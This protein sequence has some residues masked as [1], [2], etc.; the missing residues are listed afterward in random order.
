MPD[1]RTMSGMSMPSPDL[2]DGTVSVRVVRNEISNN[3]SGVTV[4]L[5]G[6]GAPRSMKTGA[7]GRA[8]FSGLPPGSTVRAVATVDGQRLESQPIE[9]PATG[10]VRT[11]LA[12]M[13]AAGAP[14]A[15]G[16]AAG[17]PAAA[18]AAPSGP[19][20]SDASVLS[21]GGNSR[22]ATEFNDDILQVFLLLEIVN[23]SSSPVSPATALVFDLPT[24]AEGTTVLDG[25]T[26]QANAKG[27]RVTVAGPF[28][29]GST[30]LQIAYRIDTFGKTLTLEQRLPLPLDAVTIAVQRLGEMKVS[31]PQVERTMENPVDRAVFV[32][33]T[34]PRLQA[35]KPLTITLSGLPHHSRMPV[36]GALGLVV[37]IVAGA[38]WLGFAPGHADAIASRRSE[39]AEQ[40]EQGLASLAALEQQHRAGTVDESRYQARRAA[41]VAQLERVYG[42]LDADGGTLGGQDIAS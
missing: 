8:V 29:P 11:I 33:G 36:Y 37:L 12:L 40:R 1:L 31:S 26:P 41:V 20:S 38:A 6:A 23:R 22:V 5:E 42:E 28:A 21:L 27:P 24:G 30:P 9:V 2:P 10:G 18:P 32:M 14:P 16:A 15:G 17:P 7:D 34:G 4:D 35:G 39:L 13:D 3:L 19:V 25:S